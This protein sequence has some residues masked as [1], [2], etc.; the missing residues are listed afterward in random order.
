MRKKSDK[1]KK[2]RRIRNPRK[3]VSSKRNGSEK[4]IRIPAIGKQ[5]NYQRK[6]HVRGRKVNAS[7]VFLIT[8][9]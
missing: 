2:V 7:W 8:G 6:K 5:K 4:E 9:E 1:G 3:R